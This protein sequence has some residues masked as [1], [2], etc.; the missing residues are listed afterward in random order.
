[1]NSIVPPEADP[2]QAG[3]AVEVLHREP[4]RQLRRIAVVRAR[5]SLPEDD[6][7]VPGGACEA[8]TAATPTTE[9]CLGFAVLQD[10]RCAE[11]GH[12]WI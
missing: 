9:K 6:I 1:M 10:I 2:P 7:R 5:T 3:N 11:P 12:W 4:C 8:A